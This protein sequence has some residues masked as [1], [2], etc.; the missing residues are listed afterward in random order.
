MTRYSPKYGI[1]IDQNDRNRN[2]WT[3]GNAHRIYNNSFAFFH[4]RCHPAAG[5][6]GEG[7]R[8]EWWA[9]EGG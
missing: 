6:T 7:G 4:N 1:L 8:V 9:R 5:I 2:E 3:L